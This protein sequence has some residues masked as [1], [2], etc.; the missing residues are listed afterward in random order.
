MRREFNKS[1]LPKQM[2]KV[3][4]KRPKK[5][6][7]NQKKIKNIKT[8]QKFVPI[9]DKP[10]QEKIFKSEDVSITYGDWIDYEFAIFRDIA[11]LEDVAFISKISKLENKKVQIIMQN[12]NDLVKLFGSLQEMFRKN[13]TRN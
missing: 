3:S 10:V 13:F 4:K 5:V 2:P 9:Y 12:Y 11:S 7:K 8:F 1:I 6:A